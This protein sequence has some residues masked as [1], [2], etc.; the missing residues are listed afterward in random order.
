MH[1]TSGVITSGV[2]R[3]I[4]CPLCVLFSCLLFSSQDG[5]ALMLVYVNLRVLPPF[6]T[7]VPKLT[8]TIAGLWPLLL[9]E[10]EATGLAGA[11]TND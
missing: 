9:S 7:I 1:R 6:G 4:T 3:D 10:K 11:S 5:R 8:L 2:K